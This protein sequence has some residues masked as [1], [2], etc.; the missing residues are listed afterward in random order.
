[1]HMVT[2]RL[3]LGIDILSDMWSMDSGTYIP[4]LSWSMGSDI[5]I[6]HCT[7]SVEGCVFN[8]IAEN[9]TTGGGIVKSTSEQSALEISEVS[10]N[11]T[12]TCH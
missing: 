9:T 11:R 1:M 2:G 7:W 4:P 5:D 3:L 8:S 10:Y 6:P 12:Q